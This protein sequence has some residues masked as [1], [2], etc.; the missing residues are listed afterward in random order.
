MCR[1]LAYSGD[2]ILVERLLFEPEHSLVNQ[3]LKAHHSKAVTNGDGFGLGW[4]SGQPH[5]G[6]YRDILPAWNDDNLRNLSSQIQSPLFFAHV[7]ASTGTATSRPNCHPFRIGKW[8]F[9]HNGQIGQY[10]VIRRTLEALIDEASYRHRFGA[11]DSELIFCLAATLGLDSDPPGAVAE[12]IAKVV[13]TMRA[14]GVAEPLRLTAALSDG[15]TLFAFRYSS[16]GQSPTLFHGRCADIDAVAKQPGPCSN[17]TL[18]VSEPLDEDTS[19]WTAIGEA[20]MLVVRDKQ[21][22]VAPFRPV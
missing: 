7:R 6:L 9:M 5:P 3:S 20:E 10:L 12:A 8:L 17:G 21:V 15:E 11:T 19:H 14:A 18:V 2:P 1:W 22:S 4:Y 13:E 16:D